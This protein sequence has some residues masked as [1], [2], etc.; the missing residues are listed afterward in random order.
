M[1]PAEP[2]ACIALV[3]LQA[4]DNGA[5]GAVMVEFDERPAVRGEQVAYAG[6]QRDRIATNADV[7]VGEQHRV[8]PARPW[9]PGENRATQ[10]R[11]P[12]RPRELDRHGR[13]VDAQRRGAAS[14]QRGCEPPRPAADVE[15][16][17]CRRLEQLVVAGA[18]QAPGGEVDRCVASVGVP[19]PPPGERRG[20]T[21]GRRL[22]QPGVVHL[23]R[24]RRH[25]APW[26][27]CRARA[28]NLVPGA[29]WATQAA[30]SGSSTSRSP[31]TR[32]VRRPS[33]ARRLRW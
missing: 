22:Q 20:R 26:P 24:G 29:A 32:T 1:G 4:H 11:S 18:W 12:G 33:A 28:P 5:A 27:S 14:G 13:D 21:C 30:S 3:V 31:G 25:A 19:Q 16:G 15:N 6:E 10:S 23:E 7:A 8:P 2:P 9:Q 17:P